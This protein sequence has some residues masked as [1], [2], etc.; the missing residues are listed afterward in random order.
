MKMN[1]KKMALAIAC[2]AILAVGATVFIGCSKEDSDEN[3]THQKSDV[4]NI[5]FS[6][7]Y[8]K[9]DEKTIM[10]C[11]GIEESSNKFTC[12]F[13]SSIINNGTLIDDSHG[14]WI[15]YSDELPFDVGDIITTE[16]DTGFYIYYQDEEIFIHDVR[17]S[18][19]SF[20]F[21]A[22]NKNDEYI[23]C[24]T[25]DIDKSLS[26]CI[27]ETKSVVAIPANIL[28]AALAASGLGSV[29]AGI[30]LAATVAKYLCDYSRQEGIERCKS[31]GCSWK[32][33]SLFPCIVKCTGSHYCDN[34][35]N[36]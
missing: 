33:E 12:D 6:S 20:S 21:T 31:L 28:R 29:I 4:E 36:Q 22:K 2:G 7:E 3:I 13:L 1:R 15:I 17:I 11:I 5:L 24:K 16:L 14:S 19:N 26:L 32:T 25:S 23:E 9:G 8:I 18:E 30:T 27:P 35:A 10:H 34:I